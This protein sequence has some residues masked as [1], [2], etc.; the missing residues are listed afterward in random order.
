MYVNSEVLLREFTNKNVVNLTICK[1]NENKMKCQTN[2]N[3][4]QT[5]QNWLMRMKKSVKKK[6]W[7]TN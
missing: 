3:V 2:Q 6:T 1:I 4:V 7:D 5:K